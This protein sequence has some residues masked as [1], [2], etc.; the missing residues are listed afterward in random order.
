V[1][2]A[3]PMFTGVATRGRSGKP[4]PKGVESDH[5]YWFVLADLHAEAVI[6]TITTSI[7]PPDELTASGV[8]AADYEVA[9]G[10]GSIAPAGHTIVA[11]LAGGIEGRAY[12]ITFVIGLADGSTTQYSFGI[13]L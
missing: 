12:V 3:I 7:A 10:C 8:Q 13:E 11:R 5:Q 2:T 9:Y 1:T 4:R 6:S